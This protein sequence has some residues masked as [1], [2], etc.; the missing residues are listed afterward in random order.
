MLKT[1]DLFDSSASDT[2]SQA[3]NIDWDAAARTRLKEIKTALR[4][5]P[6]VPLFRSLPERSPLQASCAPTSG[7]RTNSMDSLSLSNSVSLA[8]PSSLINHERSP[9][10]N[11]AQQETG[12]STTSS[13][14]ALSDYGPHVRNLI[15]LSLFAHTT[16]DEYRENHG[17]NVSVHSETQD[18]GWR[19]V[20]FGTLVHAC[21]FI[22]CPC[23][24][25]EWGP[26][27]SGRVSLVAGTAN[28]PPALSALA[29]GAIQ[30]TK[31]NTARPFTSTYPPVQA[32]NASLFTNLEVQAHALED[33]LLQ[34]ADNARAQQT[35][36]DLA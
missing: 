32:R 26:V 21:R 13:S 28:V 7:I 30:R 1:S 23:F 29:H 25:A 11:C 36:G 8:Q 9:S 31:Q 2:E 33:L 20:N 3:G 35:V 12:S 34:H 14:R 16:T 27:A 17:V 6:S 24:R 15:P 22:S 4:E 10:A 5:H 18:C 19:V